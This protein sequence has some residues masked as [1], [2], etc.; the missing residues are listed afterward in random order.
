MIERLVH[1]LVYVL[2]RPAIERLVYVLVYALE[3]MQHA[4]R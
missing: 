3:S 4:R 1:V 2:E